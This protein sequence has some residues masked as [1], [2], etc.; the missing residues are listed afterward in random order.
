MVHNCTKFP[1][2][3]HQLA[4]LYFH[5]CHQV[6]ISDTIEMLNNYDCLL[7]FTKDPHSHTDV[8][9]NVFTG[10]LKHWGNCVSWQSDSVSLLRR[11][12]GGAARRS[13]CGIVSVG[14]VVKDLQLN[15]SHVKQRTTSPAAIH[16]LVCSQ[17]YTLALFTEHI[18]DRGGHDHIFG[19][20]LTNK[21]EKES[22]QCFI[23]FISG[24]NVSFC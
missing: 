7:W 24:I 12:Q 9:S 16:H 4:T 15:E 17:P 1:I 21:K 13:L 6:T 8:L 23:E 20:R 18:H 5:M 19:S 10:C 2:F 11:G 3:L 14:V 22:V